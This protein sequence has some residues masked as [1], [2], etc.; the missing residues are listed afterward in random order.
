MSTATAGEAVYE[1]RW[2]AS[3]RV[4]RLRPHLWRFL[5]P[6]LHGARILEIGP[7]LRPTAPLQGTVFV[8]T[9]HAANVA[10][11]RR[12]GRPVR[13]GSWRMPFKDG[14]FDAILAL[15]IIEHVEEDEE[16]LGELAR[17]LRPGGLT[18]ISVPLYMR[19][20]SAV[21]DHCHH[22]RRYDPEDLIAKIERAGF[23]PQGY[24]SRPAAAKQG[25]AKAGTAF[26]DR[27]PTF[28]NWWLQNLVFPVQSLW[29]RNVTRVRLRPMDAPLPGNAGGM[30]V[31]ARRPA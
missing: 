11:R 19:L 27:F 8:E 7:G 9:S 6:E 15:E 25:L 2:G 12:G 24:T 10:L 18:V 16:M 14:A 5:E 28:V 17:V 13:G 29:Q 3:A 31:V 22:V 21:D 20:W 1:D 4:V 30:M 23:E 26:L